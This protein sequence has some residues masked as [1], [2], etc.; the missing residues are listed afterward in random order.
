M[1][2]KSFKMCMLFDFYGEMLTERQK[3]VF[4]LYYNNDMSLAEI[5]ELVGITRQGVRDLVV[6]TEAILLDTEQK[7]GIAARYDDFFENLSDIRQAA[8]E[9]KE[10]NSSGCNN[11]EVDVLISRILKDVSKASRYEAD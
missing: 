5:S 6:R 11:R 3:E 8:E 1:K 4:D 2:L 10:I 9:I 7:L